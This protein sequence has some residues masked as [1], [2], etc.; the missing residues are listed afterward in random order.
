MV[1][2]FSALGAQGSRI[3]PGR[4]WPRRAEP[5]PV[6]FPVAG[7]GWLPAIAVDGKA[8]RGAA[9]DDGLIPYLLAAV[10]HGTGAVL[11]ER[12]IGPKTNEVPEFAPLLRGAE[13]VLSAWPGTSSPPTPGTPS[14]PTQLICEELFAHYVLPSS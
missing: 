1:R 14:E 2:L 10:T 9:A 12:L 13:P 11:A 6:A 3:M 8:V 4:T 7:P 5:G